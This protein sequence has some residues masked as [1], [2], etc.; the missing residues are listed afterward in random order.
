M[1]RVLC[2]YDVRIC[3]EVVVGFVI[4]IYQIIRAFTVPRLATKC[5]ALKVIQLSENLQTPACAKGRV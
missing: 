2:N 4:K 3:E 5:F 1:S